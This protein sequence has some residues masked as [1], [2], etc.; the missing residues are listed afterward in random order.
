[1]HKKTIK[2]LFCFLLSFLLSFTINAQN[3]CDFDH[4][5]N[6]RKNTPEY[7]EFLKNIKSQMKQLEKDG[8]RIPCS[9]GVITFPVAIHYNW[10][11][12]GTTVDQCMIDAANNSIEALNQD[13]AATNADISDYDAL[14]TSCPSAYPTSALS[15]NSCI[16]FCIA[17]Y[18]H[19][20]CSGLCD[21]DLAITAG[22]FSY[23]STG[24]CFS[25]YINIFVA[26]GTGGLGI[27]PLYGVTTLG[28]NGPQ[29]DAGTWG[30]PGVLC[31]PTGLGSTFNSLTSYNLGRTLTHE[32]GHYFGCQHT[33]SFAN[34]MEG[35]ASDCS[36]D[37]GFADTPD[38]SLAN[39]GKPVVVDCNTANGSNT[40]N[41]TCSTMD[42]FCS[43]MDYCD[44]SHL[45]MYT[46][47]QSTEMYASAQ[48]SPI[49]DSNIKCSPNGMA[50]VPTADFTFGDDD[51]LFCTGDVAPYTVGLTD[52]STGCPMS[53]TWSFSGAGVSPTSSTMQNPTI[54]VTQSGDLTITLI[55]TN[56]IGASAQ[57]IK[58]VYASVAPMGSCPDCGP[59]IF[60]SGGP[61]NN[62]SPNEAYSFTYCAGANE[63]LAIDLTQVDMPGSLFSDVVLIYHSATLPAD[64]NTYDLLI[65]DNGSFAGFWV[66]NGG[67][68][69]SSAGTNYQSDEQCL[70]F[71]VESDGVTEGA[72]FLGDITCYP[73]PTCSDGFQNQGEE[74]VDCGGANCPACPSK[75]GFTFTDTGGED[76]N[77]SPGDNGQTWTLCADAAN[78]I[79][80][81][82][83]SLFLA[84]NPGTTPALL[85]YEGSSLPGNL[86]DWDYNFQ[87]GG[88]F[89]SGGSYS[90]T[91]P[92]KSTGQCMSFYFSIS[93]TETN[94]GFE[95]YVS[96]CT[97]DE[98]AGCGNS[99]TAG[100]AFTEMIDN[101]CSE[102]QI[103]DVYSLKS[104]QSDSD[105]RDCTTLSSNQTFYEITC[106]GDGGMLTVDV[107][108]NDN[109]G[110]V[111]AALY[112][113]IS[114]GCP[115]YTGGSQVACESDMDPN[116]ITVPVNADD[117]YLLVIAGENRGSF[118]IVGSGTAFESTVP[119]TLLE[120]NG[121]AIGKDV[122]LTWSSANEINND[123]FTIE[124]SKNGVDFE[125]ISDVSS[126][127]NSSQTQKYEFLDSRAYIGSSYYRLSQTDL[128][129]TYTELAII[130]VETK[131]SNDRI[132]LFPNP[133]SGNRLTIGGISPD[134]KYQVSF[135]NT[136]GES[137]L[138]STIGNDYGE[139]E[140]DVSELAIGVYFMSITDGET[141]WVEKFI[142]VR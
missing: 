22:T 20:G 118:D 90:Q 121:E 4:E 107:G 113:P 30:G 87:Q 109:G 85:A 84:N 7:Q 93:G 76:N 35:A 114:G 127:G 139:G 21:G 62:Y 8:R 60:D 42:M 66:P 111:D 33:F 131:S 17:E 132:S 49:A 36:S 12:S 100:N 51:L 122:Q 138:K 123:F 40:A 6:E 55:A 133:N 44:D 99:N 108:P 61:N 45:I 82:D 52:N 64:L 58:T 116:P 9:A 124:R 74:F 80:K 16:Q 79:L 54:T 63:A 140:L 3:R 50:S 102:N 13:F 65:G 137:V 83:F 94:P 25:D 27:A 105:S 78:E 106:D 96:C 125:K 142:K 56:A 26:S 135:V 43:F 97:A 53:W 103:G 86:N 75:C 77:Y 48:M 91:N 101:Y 10:A 37:D 134:V 120:F 29:V 115:N 71:Y 119:I 98:I 95:A 23:P 72:G 89:P 1:M 11:G 28:G 136:I 32:M 47:D 104:G 73:K 41:N 128:D 88:Y 112:G 81:F 39:Y 34:T 126:K 14:N 110:T 38:Q 2:F 68:G 15:D 59:Q 5:H 92:I 18:D 117:V 31:T 130:E 24:G 67:G 46:V 70:T 129:G 69:L 19:P 141:K 57:E